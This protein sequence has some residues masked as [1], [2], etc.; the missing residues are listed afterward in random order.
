LRSGHFNCTIPTSAAR[1]LRTMVIDPSP[2]RSRTMAMKIWRS[3]IASGRW[4][5]TESHGCALQR[6]RLCVKALA[7]ISRRADL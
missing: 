5:V 6:Q 2:V 3:G 1:Q 4:L 7:V